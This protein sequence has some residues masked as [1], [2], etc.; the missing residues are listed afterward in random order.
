MYLKRISEIQIYTEQIAI[1]YSN[2]KQTIQIS[3]DQRYV[4]YKE[5]NK[6]YNLLQNVL[7]CRNGM[8]SIEQEYSEVC[9]VLRH[10]NIIVHKR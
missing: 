2:M 9:M 6:Y 10:I 3:T 7:R 4:Q 1:Y 8:K 5:N